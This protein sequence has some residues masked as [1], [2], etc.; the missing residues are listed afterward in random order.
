LWFGSWKNGQSS[1]LP[2]WVKRDFERFPRAQIV[3]GTWPVFAGGEG[4]PRAQFTGSIELLSP[5]SDASRDADARAYAALMR[6]LKEMDG[7][8]HTVIGIQVENEVGIQG[9]TR[10]RSP[11]A[12]K[13]YDGPVP[14]ELM[15]YLQK[16]KDTLIPELRKVW[17]ATGFKT[18]GTWEEVFGKGRPSEEIFMAWHF[19]RYIGRVVEAGKAEYPI[20]MVTNCPQSGFGTAPA[21]VKGGQS[22]GPMPDA[23]DVWRA[24]APQIDLFG[25]DVYGFDFAR[26]TA[27]FT[28]SGNPL[29]VNE[30]VAGREGAARALYAF[31]RYN[32]ICFSPFG[33]DG[34][35]APNKDFINGYDLL[36]QLT[37]LITEH[38]GKGTMSGVL[39]EPKDPPQKV[40]LGDYT[41]E[42]AFLM[43]RAGRG[44][45]APE[46]PSLAGAILI[47]TGP[48]EYIA[49][50]FGV[51]IA[52]TPNT[53]GPP[54]GGVGTVE[55]GTFV[56]GRW[57]PG[58]RLAGDETTQGDCVVLR[59]PPGAVASE[60]PSVITPSGIQRF[61][62]YRYR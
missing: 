17:E 52:V 57:V 60:P 56:N 47:Q 35:R 36:T 26:M 31:G 23:M 49:A 29:F 58:R 27:R 11:A 59:W 25:I 32:A 41:L 10:D 62:V 40:R 37:P 1:Y 20:P 2:D 3:N 18:S 42:V 16:H 43:P 19:A 48:E 12:N 46:P 44:T 7:R 21:P 53:P 54:L 55:E 38:Q 61:T 39:L 51:T 14:K 22:G 33:I 50:G 5:L 24:G 4:R 30:T 9:D 13:A 6:H 8:E 34:S 15:D 45:P 28:Q